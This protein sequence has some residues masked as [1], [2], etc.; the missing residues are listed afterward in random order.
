M[1]KVLIFFLTYFLFFSFRAQD[2]DS[3]KK[4]L[5]QE[6]EASQGPAFLHL[7][8]AYYKLEKN[9]SALYYLSFAEKIASP[10]RQPDLLA[11]ILNLKAEIAYDSTDYYRTLAFC[12]SALR[13]ANDTTVKNSIRLVLAN[14]YSQIGL[15]RQAYKLYRDLIKFYRQ[16]KD[17]LTL[18]KLYSNI[19]SVFFSLD[20]LDSAL[21][22]S[23]LVIKLDSIRHNT[24]Y[25]II[26]YIQYGS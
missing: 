14:T 7:A 8:E 6:H 2:L 1:K 21:Y 15:Y 18:S 4:A 3:L 23:K 20:M 9:D 12:D 24:G 22:Y 25:L 16:R 10:S 13:I 17:T 26:D 5:K 19:G 11:Q